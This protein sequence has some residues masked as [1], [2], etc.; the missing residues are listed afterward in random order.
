[1][2]IQKTI[3]S[4]ARDSLRGNWT[5]AIAG[6]FTLISV[7]ISVILFFAL[8]TETFTVTDNSGEVKSGK[9]LLVLAA[10]CLTFLAFVAVSPVKN[11]FFRYFYN[12]SDTGEGDYHD[13]FYFFCGTKRYFSAIA[14]NIFKALRTSLIVIVCYLA[15][16][17]LFFAVNIFWSAFSLS[18]PASVSLIVCNIAAILA[19]AL[20]SRRLLVYELIFSSD[21]VENPFEAGGVILRKFR[22]NFLSLTVSFLPWILSCFFV[23]PALYVIPYYTMSAATSTK[24]LLKLYKEGKLV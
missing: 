2:R 14:F 12:L 11:G 24:W 6:L 20:I 3:R 15:V 19:A 23:L 4:Q 21:S 1:M 18:V 13:M 7:I 9:T 10:L 8:L 17:V 22:F 16:G 5:G